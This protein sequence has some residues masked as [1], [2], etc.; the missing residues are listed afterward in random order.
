M[1]KIIFEQKS[2]EIDAS[3][4]VLGR[5]H[6]KFSCYFNYN[7]KQP[8]GVFYKKKLFLKIFKNTYFEEHLWPAASIKR[9]LPSW[10]FDWI[11]KQNRSFP[12]M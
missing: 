5:A 11:E 6:I 12:M 2:G 9:D 4:L 8:P 3:A 10:S 7:Q 1:L